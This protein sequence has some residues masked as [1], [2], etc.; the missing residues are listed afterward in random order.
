MQGTV[1]LHSESEKTRIYLKHDTNLP[2]QISFKLRK[3]PETPYITF[4]TN[5]NEAKILYYSFQYLYAILKL[6][7]VY[8]VTDFYLPRRTYILQ[9]VRYLWKE[10]R[11]LEFR[12][13]K[14]ELRSSMMTQEHV[15][16][17]SRQ[18]VNVLRKKSD[19]PGLGKRI[20]P[21]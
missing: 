10:G 8:L 13:E 12:I 4:H 7:V 14:Q 19:Y 16:E 5:W 2:S 18:K 3:N 21:K 15:L 1:S 11:E 6:P 20:F 9:W 17:M